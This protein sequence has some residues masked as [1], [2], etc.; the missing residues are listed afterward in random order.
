M[1][2][3]QVNKGHKL[4]RQTR[5]DREGVP[6]LRL[7]TTRGEG[8]LVKFKTTSVAAEL[9]STIGGLRR[10]DAPRELSYSFLLRIASLSAI[11]MGWHRQ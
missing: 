9:T 6:I 3:A 2:V 4:R 5:G 8:G 10:F 7:L 11:L 1:N